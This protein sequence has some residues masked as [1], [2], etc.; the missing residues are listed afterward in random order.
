MHTVGVPCEKSLDSD[1]EDKFGLRLFIPS[2]I[3]CLNFCILI[4]KIFRVRL[5]HY[6][7]DPFNATKMLQSI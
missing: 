4:A 5:L 2:V 7:C 6:R 3:N 1:G